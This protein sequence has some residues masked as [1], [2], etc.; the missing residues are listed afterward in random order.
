MAIDFDTRTAPLT[1]AEFKGLP[2]NADGDL[3]D[4]SDAYPFI[5]DAQ[6]EALSEDDWSRMI[7]LDEEVAS[8]LEDLKAEFGF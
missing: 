4:L 5:T 8:M 2:R 3:I 6:R 1:E 7:E